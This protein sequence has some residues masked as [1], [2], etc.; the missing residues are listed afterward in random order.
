MWRLFDKDGHRY[1]EFKAH[2]TNKAK[3]AEALRSV[4]R[5]VL[6]LIDEIMD[7]V[8]VTAAA[9][10]DGAVLD[11][12]FLRVLLDV[13]NDV[14]NCVAVV[15]MIA[16]DK[17]DMAMNRE[18]EKHRAEMEALLTRNART[19]AVT[20]GGD[21][22]EII[23]RRLFSSRVPVD[24]AHA[25][26]ERFLTGMSGAWQTKVFKKLGGYTGSEFRRR[27]ERCYPFHPDLI[28]LA[29]DEWAQHAGFQRVRSII[30]SSPPR[31][32]SR[33]AAPP[34]GEWAPEL[35]SQR[36]PALQSNCCGVRCSAPA[37]RGR[38]DSGESAGSPAWHHR[39]A[40]PERGAGPRL[41]TP[42]TKGWIRHNP[43]AGRSIAT[44]LFLGRCVPR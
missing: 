40:Q 16:S 18:G 33:Q 41:D 5:P 17:D 29:E 38:Q 39:P 11:M 10:P 21:F 20:G 19:T 6:V 32:T 43:R 22:A 1:D 23:Q 37:C 8:R 14:P 36:R 28:A 35:M 34:A 27:V 26:A 7:Y 42:G 12:A 2:I 24:A 4:G 15:V 31:R 30:R 25:T 3:M 13:V 9:D 44:A